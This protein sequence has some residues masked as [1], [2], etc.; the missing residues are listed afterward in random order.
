MR[1][2][3]QDDVRG[4]QYSLMRLVIRET[5]GQFRVTVAR[6]LSPRRTAYLASARAVGMA[7]CRERLLYSPERIG[8]SWGRR[9]ARAVV[10]A[11]RAF[12]ELHAAEP[13]VAV[14]ER[15]IVARCAIGDDWREDRERVRDALARFPS[16][17]PIDI[18]FS[19]D[20]PK[21]RLL[22]H[23]RV[24]AREPARAPAL[25]PSASLTPSASVVLSLSKDGAALKDRPCAA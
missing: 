22:E 4:P 23:M 14:A 12:E 6:L 20:I 7:I 25:I 8:R 1:V 2:E 17:R 18:A 24:L 19:L 16:A 13:G 15:A 3:R 21:S 11:L 5:A 10:A 9:G